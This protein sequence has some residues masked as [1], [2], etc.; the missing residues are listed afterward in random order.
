MGNLAT[1]FTIEITG[2]YTIPDGVTEI[3]I[4]N[5]GAAPCSWV[6]NQSSLGVPSAPISLGAGEAFAYG[7]I[8]RGRK[9][10]TIDARGTTV[11]LSLTS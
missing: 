8:G 10:F 7:Y 2:L 3:F 11:Q 4:E 5:T 9:G 6:G 1:I